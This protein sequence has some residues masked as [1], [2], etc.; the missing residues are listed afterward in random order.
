MHWLKQL[1]AATPNSFSRHRQRTACQECQGSGL[2]LRRHLY[3]ACGLVACAEAFDQAGALDKLE[4]FAT[5]APISIELPRNIEQ[6]TLLRATTPVSTRTSAGVVPLRAGETLRLEIIGGISGPPWG[7]SNNGNRKCKG[8]LGKAVQH[9]NKCGAR[10][11]TALRQQR[12]P[13]D[14]APLPMSDESDPETR[15]IQMQL[16]GLALS[17]GGMRSATSTWY[18]PGVGRIEAAARLR[19][20]VDGIRRRLHGILVVRV[21]L[22]GSARAASNRE[23]HSRATRLQAMSAEHSAIRFLRESATI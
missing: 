10:S 15:A 2:R 13:A 19:L 16:T 4:A 23:S 7:R 12:L 22:P 6:I 3:R 5:M 18:D 8:W 9:F 14:V 1:P 20:F 11:S 21:D 17:G